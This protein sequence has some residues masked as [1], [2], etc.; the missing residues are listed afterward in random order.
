MLAELIGDVKGGVVPIKALYRALKDL[1]I[2]VP[3]ARKAETATII[4]IATEEMREMTN[5]PAIIDLVGSTLHIK[6]DADYKSGRGS[7]R[8]LLGDVPS[9]AT[10]PFACRG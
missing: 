8:L 2:L 9:S 10:E 5:G 1:A 7:S 6:R 4:A 3:A